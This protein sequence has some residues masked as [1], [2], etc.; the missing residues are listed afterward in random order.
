MFFR[1]DLQ[2]Y[3]KGIRNKEFLSIKGREIIIEA[4]EPPETN[5]ISGYNL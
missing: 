1:M 5:M 4:A 2:K 3:V